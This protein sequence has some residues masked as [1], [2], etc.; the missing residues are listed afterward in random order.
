MRQPRSKKLE[1]LPFF[2][3]AQ[4]NPL[5]SCSF[6]RKH[7]LGKLEKGEAGEIDWVS[8]LFYT[9]WLFLSQMCE[10]FILSWWRI[11]KIKMYWW[12]WRFLTVL[13]I[14]KNVWRCSGELWE[15]PKLFKSDNCSLFCLWHFKSLFIAFIHCRYTIFCGVVDQ[16]SHPEVQVPATPHSDSAINNRKKLDTIVQLVQ[17]K[18]WR[19]TTVSCIEPKRIANISDYIYKSVGLCRAPYLVSCQLSLSL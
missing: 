2:K 19:S 13:N 9:C 3:H 14:A 6:V 17:Q 7:S 18:V 1:V 8:L 12:L 10:I 16:H 11:L 15:L 4:C 5:T